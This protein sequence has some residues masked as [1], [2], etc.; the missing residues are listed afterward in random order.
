MAKEQEVVRVT[1]KIDPDAYKKVK[2]QAK[3][4]GVSVGE[5]AL[6]LLRDGMLAGMVD[7]TGGQVWV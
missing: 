7:Y 3:Y 4:W 5:R 1:Y 2:A 6:G